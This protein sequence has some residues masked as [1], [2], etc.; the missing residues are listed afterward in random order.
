MGLIVDNTCNVVTYRQNRG[1]VP[2]QQR[3]S[4]KNRAKNLL[5]D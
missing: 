5:M 2:S 4:S 1:G 3:N